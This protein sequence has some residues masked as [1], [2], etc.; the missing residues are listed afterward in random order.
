M[1]VGVSIADIAVQKRSDFNGDIL[2]VR[3]YLYSCLQ[4][5]PV[6]TFMILGSADKIPVLVV[7]IFHNRLIVITISSK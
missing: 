7:G 1:R 2:L 3:S 6:E 5:D 4:I